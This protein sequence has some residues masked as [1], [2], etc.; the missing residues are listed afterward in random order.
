[1]VG[2]VH[3]C[4]DE[5]DSLLDRV[6]FSSADRLVLV[7]DLVARGPDPAGVIAT[8]R[9]VSARSVR[10][11][12]E[13]RLIKLARQGPEGLS[14]RLRGVYETT[15]AQ[16]EETDLAWLETLPLWLDLPEHGARIVHAGLIPGVPIEEQSPRTLMYVRSVGR[17]GEPIEERGHLPWAIRYVGPP[18]V[19]FGHYAREEVQIH[20]FATGLDTGAVYGGRLTAMVLDEAEVVPQSPRRRLTTLVSVPA[21]RAYWPR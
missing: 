7:G 9:R 1:M 20:R 16:L 19:L 5:L 12:H 6:A 18:H 17:A 2:D 14:A 4:S 21:Q 13:D 11:N 10:G 15:L 8:A 3:G